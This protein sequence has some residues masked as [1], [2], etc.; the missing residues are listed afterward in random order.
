MLSP[1][2][3]PSSVGR[4]RLVA[5]LVAAQLA[6]IL[7]ALREALPSRPTRRRRAANV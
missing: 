4:W 3:R 1:M 5:L 7:G 6:T 2:R